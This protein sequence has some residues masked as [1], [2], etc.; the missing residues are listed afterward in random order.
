M[1]I[2]PSAG[3]SKRCWSTFGYIHNKSRNRLKNDRVNKLVFIYTNT[4]LLEDFEYKKAWF[5]RDKVP[6]GDNKDD[7]IH[8]ID[9]LSDKEL[10]PL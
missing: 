1:S 10:A 5:D 2:V 6:K 7:E 4:K 8:I 3:A 9:D